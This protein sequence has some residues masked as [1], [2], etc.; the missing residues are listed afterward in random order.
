MAYD[1]YNFKNNTKNDKNGKLVYK[2]I[3]Y[4]KVPVSDDDIYVITKETDRLDLLAYKYYGD[5]TMWW[6]IAKANN[7]GNTFFIPAN[8]Q[9][10]IPKDISGLQSDLDEL[11]KE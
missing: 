9:I 11:N 5:T 10:R 7:I 1:R 4:P 2:S 6:I 8:T 3:L